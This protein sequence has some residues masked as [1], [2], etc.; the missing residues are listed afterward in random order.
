MCQ[1]EEQELG[2]LRD[3][4]QVQEITIDPPVVSSPLDGELTTDEELITTTDQSGLWS[5]APA[6]V[7]AATLV[8]EDMEP[9]DP[10][11]LWSMIQEKVGKVSDDRYTSVPEYH[12]GEVDR[13]FSAVRYTGDRASRAAGSVLAAAALVAGSSIGAGVLALPAAAAAGFL[14]SSAAALVAY[15]YTTMSGLLI[16]ELTLNRMA[17]TGSTD[18]TL[19]DLFDSRLGQKWSWLGTASTLFLHYALLVAYLSLG[20]DILSGFL[21]AEFSTAP[22][23]GQALFAAA[24]GVTV[25]FAGWSGVQIVNDVALAGVLGTFAAI[26]ATLAGNANFGSLIDMSNQHPEATLSCF[27]LLFLAFTYQSIVPKIVKDLEGNRSKILQ[28][29]IGGTTVP[30]L[31]YLMWNAVFLGSGSD[32]LQLLQSGDSWVTAFSSLA[33]VSGVGVFSN[34][35][36][37]AWIHIFKA[38][39]PDE[40]VLQGWNP[41]LLALVFCPPL[42]LSVTN[43]DLYLDS[44]EYGGLFGVS[45]L[46]L[47][48]APIMVW[49]ERYG[50][51]QAPLVTKPLVPLGKIPLGSMWKAAATLILEQGAEKLLDFS[52]E[53]LPF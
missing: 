33:I 4:L 2:E 43:P 47:V 53:A 45:T 13:L 9:T 20:G 41:A 37:E 49:G 18:I 48:L 34:S 51:A 14:P 23:T 10:L 17:D 21:P 26:T 7:E 36:R 50:K 8:V 31:M 5:M 38:N 44:L 3:S 28:A 11:G 27:P 22:G 25:A 16:A 46:F 24:T 30:L 35:L 29:L 1:E 32:P 42:A 39:T 6:A 15:A 52:K 40:D 19:L 12:R